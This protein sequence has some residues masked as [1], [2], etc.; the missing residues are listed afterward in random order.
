MD[1]SWRYQYLTIRVTGNGVSDFKKWTGCF[2]KRGNGVSTFFLADKRRLTE[3]DRK[4]KFFK[5]VLVVRPETGEVNQPY[6]AQIESFYAAHANSMNTRSAKQVVKE[7]TEKPCFLCCRWFY[8]PSDT[9]FCSVGNDKELFLSQHFDDN[10]PVYSVIK[11]V[12]VLLVVGEKAF[13]NDAERGWKEAMQASG[14]G[15]PDNYVC[16]FFYD[17][18]KESLHQLKAAL[19]SEYPV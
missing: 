6:V 11:K 18:Q 14:T 7:K 5:F 19:T 16:R 17:Y 10:A 8:R 13:I 12:Q 2:Q 4:Y 1:I 3:L 9:V 15:E